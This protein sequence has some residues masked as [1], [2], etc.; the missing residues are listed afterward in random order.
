M[1]WKT[2]AAAALLLTFG[3]LTLRYSQQA[4]Q[5]V[6]DGLLLCGNVILPAL[7]PFLILSSLVVELGLADSLGTL[8]RHWMKPVFGVG[9]AGASALALGLVGGYPVGAKTVCQL[10]NRG[11]CSRQE[12]QRL[13]AFCCNCGPGFILGVAGGGIFGSRAVGLALWAVHAGAALLVGLLF[14]SYHVKEY[15]LSP[16]SRPCCAAPPSCPAAFLHA[17]TGSLQ[18]CLN[19]SSFV[20][21]FSVLNRLLT[22]SGLLPSQGWPGTVLAGILELSTGV[23]GLKEVSPLPRLCLAAF[24]LGWGGCSVHCQTLVFLSE[25]GLSPGTYL[26]GKLLHGLLSALLILPF[27]RVLT[28]PAFLP[29]SPCL[30][31]FVQVLSRSA[32]ASLALWLLG[33]LAMVR[34]L[35]NYAGKTS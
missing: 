8:A 17:V 22:L 10:Y 14:R 31:G 24:F 5:A 18:A 12:A 15:T 16:V 4:A 25:S 34:F 28:L 11:Q 32:T 21:C 35:K 26:A 30:P 29:Q 20:L 3:A 9:G 23:A 19:I 6:R 7:F 2:P 27:G 13:L 1:K 33:C